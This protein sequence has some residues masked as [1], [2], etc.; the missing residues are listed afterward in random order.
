MGFCAHL[1]G[2]H[3]LVY[4]ISAF[5]GFPYPISVL[6]F[7]LYAALQAIQM[8]IFALLVRSVGFGPLHIYPALFWVPLEFL[9]PLLFPWHIANSQVSFTWFIQT[10]DLVGPYG[11]S[12]VV[13]W[14]NAT[15]FNLATAKKEERR[16][17]LLPF[18]YA[19]LSVL[20]SLA[21]GVQRLASISEEIAG[22]RKISVASVQGNVDID[23]KWNPDAGAEEP[24]QAP[25][26]NRAIGSGG[27]GDLAGVVG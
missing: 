17:S 3:W 8:M 9:F 14:F 26:A 27:A 19:A 21:Y 11:A 7:L 13:V 6:I 2:F 15:V 4:T 5:G 12:F 22:A 20:V 24:R 25:R 23:M 16:A 1:I 18:A 10:A